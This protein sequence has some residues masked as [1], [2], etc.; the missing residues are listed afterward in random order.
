MFKILSKSTFT[1]LLLI[2]ATVLFTGCVNESEPEETYTNLIWQDEF[3]YQGSVDADLWSF[4]IGTGEEIFGRPGWGNNELQYY[5]DHP[6]N[7]IVE[8]GM[9][10]I[11]VR[12]ESFQGANYTSSKI[13]TRGSFERKYG[14]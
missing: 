12:E 1:L 11:T 7:I 6:E 8:D 3:N 10:K 9:L 2:T 5:T 14:R 4:D 13:L